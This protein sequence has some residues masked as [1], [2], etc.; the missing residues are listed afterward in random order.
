MEHKEIESKILELMRRSAYLYENNII[1]EIQNK[2]GKHNANPKKIKHILLKLSDKKF[3]YKLKNSHES[4]LNRSRRSQKMFGPEWRLNKNY[5]KEEANLKIVERKE[6][7]KVKEDFIFGEIE[8][9]KV[10][11]LFTDRKEL[12]KAGIH[13]PPMHGIWGR[14]S[15]GACSIVLSGGYEDDIDEIDF[16]YY[17]GAGGQNIPGG[18]QVKDQEF[19]K[20]NQA[21]KLSCDYSLPVRVTRGHQLLNG[22]REGYRYD[23]LYNVEKYE[24]VKGKSGFFICRF[25]MTSISSIENLQTTLVETF[26]EDYVPVVREDTV[27]SKIKRSVLN[28]E[29]IKKIYDHKCQVCNISINTPNGNIAIGAHIKALGKPHNGPDTIDNMLCLCPNHHAQYDAFGFYIDPKTFKIV[30]LDELN[31]KKIKIDKKHKIQ[32]EFLEYHFVEFQKN[33]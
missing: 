30:G 15:E 11:D 10:G 18:K 29:K 4:Q 1:S 20:Q 31:D 13:K 16:I 2:I 9:V 21:L 19:K 8:G 24:R 22:P 6:S 27:V 28:R 32:R 26:K 14:E 3:I 25:Y 12:A 7:P 33:N 17:T 5:S 23:G